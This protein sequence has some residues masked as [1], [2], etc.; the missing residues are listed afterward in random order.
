MSLPTAST[1]IEIPVR[2]MGFAF[3]KELPRHW[4]GGDPFETH[5]YNALSLTFPLGEKQFVESV[6][7][8]AD[9]ITD[10]QLKDDVR[11]F[12]GQEVQHGKEHEAF[13]AWIESLGLPA[14]EVYDFIS[15]RITKS[16]AELRPIQQLAITCALEHFTAIMAESGLSNPEIFASFDAG[17]RDLWTWHAIEES[18]HKAVAFDV[19]RHVGGSYRNRVTTMAFVTVVFIANQA[20]F[21]RQLMV[22]DGESRNLRSYA[23]G[24]L[25]Y[26]GPRGYFTRLVPDYLAYY[27]RDFHPWQQD[28]RG[29][30][31][32]HRAAIEARAKRVVPQ[33]MRATAS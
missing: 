30:V 11:A 1:P 23:R 6:R 9:R 22:A 21:H 14:Q 10:A 32:R 19:Y 2:H 3:P 29:S 31:A 27:R 26:W 28:N 15:E 4:V 7:A 18:E 24:F 33:A 20:R 16:N 13:N 8:F 17:V 25:K 5:L 12:V